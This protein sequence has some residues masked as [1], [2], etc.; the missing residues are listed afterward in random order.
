MQGWML[1]STSSL[2][3][4]T[5]Q[6]KLRLLN[7]YVDRTSALFSVICNISLTSAIVVVVGSVKPAIVNVFNSQLWEWTE[8]HYYCEYY[9]LKV[10]SQTLRKVDTHSIVVEY[11]EIVIIIVRIFQN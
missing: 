1:R 7:G 11:L 10:L 9:K 3:R 5:F 6:I 8:Q 2:K 4:L